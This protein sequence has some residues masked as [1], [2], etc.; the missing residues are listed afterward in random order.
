MVELKR[1]SAQMEESLDRTTFTPMKMV[2]ITEENHKESHWCNQTIRHFVCSLTQITSGHKR[3][4]INN[5]NDMQNAV[6]GVKL[7]PSKMVQTDCGFSSALSG[8]LVR[9]DGKMES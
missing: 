8:K 2:S 5:L 4:K 3:S 1:S 6:F 9:V 7:K